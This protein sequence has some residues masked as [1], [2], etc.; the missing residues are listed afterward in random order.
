M[1]VIF[2]Y[3]YLIKYII[4]SAM[5]IL[6]MDSANRKRHS[7]FEKGTLPLNL[8]FL[9]WG[10]VTRLQFIYYLLAEG[11]LAFSVALVLVA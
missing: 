2:T 7:A 5:T 6:G 11:I 8:H 4:L 9:E 1:Y 3:S 10:G